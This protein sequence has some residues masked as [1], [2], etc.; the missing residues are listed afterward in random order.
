MRDVATDANMAG[1]LD[2]D[3]LNFTTQVFA[4]H[5]D[6]LWRPHSAVI[7][8]EKSFYKH[9]QAFPRFMLVDAVMRE[10]DEDTGHPRTLWP[11]TPL[12]SGHRSGDLLYLL[13]SA[14]PEPVP[15]YEAAGTDD[16]DDEV[17]IGGVF[18]AE[19]TTVRGRPVYRYFP[20]DVQPWGYYKCRYDWLSMIWMA[21][22]CGVNIFGKLVLDRADLIDICTG[23]RFPHELHVDAEG[24]FRDG[25]FH[26][27]PVGTLP[28]VQD[29]GGWEARERQRYEQWIEP[30]ADYQK[31]VDDAIVLRNRLIEGQSGLTG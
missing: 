19:I 2:A 31:A 11:T 25:F 29:R 4:L 27:W 18:M 16:P 8:Q 5:K 12:L 28:H 13:A 17:L 30:D 14:R 22:Q 26:S 1:R 24:P 23:R 20:I 3:L 7:L 9:P 6:Y 15:F 10:E 21:K